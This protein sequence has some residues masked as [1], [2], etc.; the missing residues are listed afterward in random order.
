MSFGRHE[1]IF[2]EENKSKGRKRPESS[3]QPSVGT[4]FQL[5]IPWPVAL[6]Q[7]RPPL[8][9][10]R[11]SVH[12]GP[13]GVE[14]FSVNGTLSL[15]CLSHPRGQVHCAF[16]GLSWRLGRP[17]LKTPCGPPCARGTVFV[18]L[19]DS[20][21]EPSGVVISA[22][23][24]V[25]RQLPR[26]GALP[27]LLRGNITTCSEPYTGSLLPRW[28]QSWVETPWCGHQCLGVPSSRS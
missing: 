18:W 2:S 5:A 19:L 12:Q 8:H 27:P 10:L 25:V 15:N 4:S 21:T 11:A 13:L 6:Q 22:H 1:E 24:T 7:S 23:S 3:F 17:H 26:L 20:F 16:R 9:Q 14:K 28:P